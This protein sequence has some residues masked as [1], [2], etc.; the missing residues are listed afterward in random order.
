[1][2]TAGPLIGDGA[3]LTAS[4]DFGGPCCCHNQYLLA[5]LIDDEAPKGQAG[6]RT[7]T[8]PG[9]PKMGARAAPSPPGTATSRSNCTPSWATILA[10]NVRPLEGIVVGLLLTRSLLGQASLL[11]SSGSKQ[12]QVFER[13]RVCLQGMRPQ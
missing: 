2:R 10:G 3:G 5:A 9:A 4:A 12:S 13:R 8:A 6:D 7:H 1:M 11:G